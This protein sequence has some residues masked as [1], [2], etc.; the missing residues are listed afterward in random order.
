M[1]KRGRG[2]GRDKVMDVD[3]SMG[4]DGLDGVWGIYTWTFGMSSNVCTAIMKGIY[5]RLHAGEED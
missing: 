2:L 1:D 5:Q 3:D 4:A